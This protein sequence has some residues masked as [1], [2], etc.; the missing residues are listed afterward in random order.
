MIVIET[1]PNSLNTN[2]N[3]PTFDD[4]PVR[5]QVLLYIS[6]GLVLDGD[7]HVYLLLLLSVQG[8]DQGDLPSRGVYTARG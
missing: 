2:T 1:Y 4:S 5:N 7:D 6:E 8:S 3:L